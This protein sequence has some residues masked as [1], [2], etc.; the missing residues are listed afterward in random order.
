MASVPYSAWLEKCSEHGIDDPFEGARLIGMRAEHWSAVGKLSSAYLL[1]LD[2]VM[3]QT[4]ARRIAELELAL[5]NADATLARRTH[6]R[7]V[8]KA[9]RDDL[10]KEV[11]DLKAEV[12]Y[13]STRMKEAEARVEFLER[14]IREGAETVGVIDGDLRAENERL[15][16]ENKALRDASGWQ[17]AFDRLEAESD[18]WR[19][20]AY[21]WKAR[22]EELFERREN[23]AIGSRER[24]YTLKIRN[25]VPTILKQEQPERR[26]SRP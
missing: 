9:D 22:Y 20:R 11:T 26:Q 15:Q 3:L 8:I 6:A 2:G 23:A 1:A 19:E 5:K 18:Q 25:C 16:A 7:D 10:R 14:G 24:V 17:P 21:S 4:E 12:E 13:F